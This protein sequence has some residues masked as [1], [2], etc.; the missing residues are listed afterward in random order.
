MRNVCLIS[1]VLPKSFNLIPMSKKSTEFFQSIGI[2]PAVFV[3]IFEKVI[4]EHWLSPGELYIVK[5]Y[6]LKRS[7]FDY[8]LV[9]CSTIRLR[10]YIFILSNNTRSVRSIL[11]S[12]MVNLKPIKLKLIEIVNI[13]H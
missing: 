4:W 7:I 5:G 9:K 13:F 1:I 8:Q 6:H 11:F 12:V 10:V 2:F 3:R